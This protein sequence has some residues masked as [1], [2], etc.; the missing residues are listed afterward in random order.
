M[1]AYLVR[2]GGVIVPTSVAQGPW[3]G[4]VSGHVLSGLL[5]ATLERTAGDAAFQ[6]AR[7]T[8]DLLRPALMEPVDV[9]AELVRAGGRIRLADATLTQ[10]GN[11]IAR[12]SAVFLRRGEHPD[13]QVWSREVTIPAPP[14]PMPHSEQS[15]FA[16]HASGWGADKRRSDGSAPKFAWLRETRPLIDGEVLSRFTRA[17]MAGDVTS[18][19]MHWGT[20]GMRFINIDCTVTLSRLPESELVGIAAQSH[21]GH[22]GVAT[23]VATLFD[24]IGPI[25]HAMATALADSRFSSPFAR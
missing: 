10:R 25:G 4:A 1:G 3:G 19:V 24:A 9:D 14:V 2:D 7:L 8:V 23:G 12:A 15:P 17:A 21:L 16:V 11:L 20:A 22:D 18:T 13:Q 5:G 6:P